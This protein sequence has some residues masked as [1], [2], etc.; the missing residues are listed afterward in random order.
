M[1]LIKCNECGKDISSTAEKCPHCGYKTE[2]G[3]SVSMAKG[4]LI[5]FAF[6]VVE[7]VIGL[8]LTLKNHEIFYDRIEIIDY[9]DDFFEETQEAIQQYG[10]GVVLLIFGIIGFI[11]FAIDAHKLSRSDYAYSTTVPVSD[12]EWECSRCYTVNS[13]SVNECPRC[14]AF[15]AG[16]TPPASERIPTW[17]LI[18][19]ENQKGED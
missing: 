13:P 4:T 15:K 7:F 3:Q 19:M 8:V 1:A 18:E 12:V 10:I 17:K 14:G 16:Y 5:W 6:S 11:G 2:H 9:Y